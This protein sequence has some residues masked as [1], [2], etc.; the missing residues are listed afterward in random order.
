[1]D[2]M[3]RSLVAALLFM[4]AG[5]AIARLDL[6]ALPALAQQAAPSPSAPA[7][8]G[9]S[10][11]P[12]KAGGTVKSAAR[13]AAAT[14]GPDVKLLLEQVNRKVEAIE[15]SLDK[16]AAEAR[17]KVVTYVLWAAGGLFLLMFVSALLGGAVA[18]LL[19]RRSRDA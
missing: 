3:I 14:L 9:Q 13:D 15:Q 12:D 5:F 1:M 11:V 16:L 4:T 17:A 2:K 19:L 10:V 8:A 18:A 7:P 6:I